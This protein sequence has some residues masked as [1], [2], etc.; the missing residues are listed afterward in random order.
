MPVAPVH[1]FSS[2]WPKANRLDNS[3]PITEFWWWVLVWNTD[4]NEEAETILVSQTASVSSIGLPERHPM[5]QS[6]PFFRCG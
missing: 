6:Y 5:M 4:K 2:T 1:M 3:I